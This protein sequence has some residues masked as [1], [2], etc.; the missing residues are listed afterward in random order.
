MI[1]SVKEGIPGLKTFEE[2]DEE[3]NQIHDRIAALLEVEKVSNEEEA[4]DMEDFNRKLQRKNVQKI[5]QLMEHESVTDNW[6]SARMELWYL[7]ESCKQVTNQGILCQQQ[8]SH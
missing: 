1:S 8:L 2:P 7:D 3:L 4:P 5:P 6:A